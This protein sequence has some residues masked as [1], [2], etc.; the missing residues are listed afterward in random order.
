[1][2]SEANTGDSR[3]NTMQIAIKTRRSTP[4]CVRN[5]QFVTWVIGDEVMGDG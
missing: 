5:S 2:R 4:S 3:D 1:L